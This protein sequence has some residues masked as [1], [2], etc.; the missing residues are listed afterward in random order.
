MYHIVIRIFVS[1]PAI[2]RNLNK[3]GCAKGESGPP[4]PNL[5]YGPTIKKQSFQIRT[6][7]DAVLTAFLHGDQRI[8]AF[9]VRDS[10]HHNSV[11]TR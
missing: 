5:I 2:S 10:G 3:N 11:V 7:S 8:A 9:R 1:F 6:D 4:L